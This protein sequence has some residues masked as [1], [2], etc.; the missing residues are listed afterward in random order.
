MSMAVCPGVEL[1][2]CCLHF[3]LCDTPRHSISDA[4]NCGHD[5][6]EDWCAGGEGEGL[7][8]SM[9]LSLSLRFTDRCE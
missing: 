4:G 9:L 7:I 6:G 3:A 1:T 2:I 8:H 5:A